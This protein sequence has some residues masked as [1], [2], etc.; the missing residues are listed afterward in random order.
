MM[1]ERLR[2]RQPRLG[3]LAFVVRTPPIRR[4]RSPW[5]AQVTL[6]DELP[7]RGAAVAHVWT[8]AAWLAR[9]SP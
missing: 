7:V 2:E 1:R 6:N 9:H 4:T 3:G 5:G 8:P